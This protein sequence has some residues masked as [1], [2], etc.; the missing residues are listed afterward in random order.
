[1]VTTNRSTS[2]RVA[3]FIAL[4]LAFVSVEGCYYMQAV[5]GH[6]EVMRKRRPLDDVLTDADADE[7][8]KARLRLIREARQF[9]VD[10]LLL[11]DNDSY[12]TYAD[13]ERDYVV[14][15]VFAAPEFSLEPKQWCFPVAGCVAYKGYFD[16]DRARAFAQ[17]LEHKGYDVAVGGVAAYSTLGRFDDPVLNTMLHW[18][19]N[20]LVETLFHELAHQKLY[21]KG[22]SGFNESFASAVAEI[23]LERWL[24]SRGKAVDHR[25][26][27]EYQ[28]LQMAML[29][30]VSDYRSRL[31][32]LY[33][34]EL[35]DELRR[36][37][38]RALLDELSARAEGLVEDSGLDTT[39]WL[40][41]PL[42]NARLASIGLY[43]GEVP[44]FRSLLDA[45]QESLACFYDRAESLARMDSDARAAE[46]RR[47]AG[48]AN[49]DVQGVERGQ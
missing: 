25:R 1:V 20:V 41:A 22:D 28:A 23:G 39:N 13:L 48:D 36:T 16:E 21:I 18:S 12:R 3:I 40:A 37:Q 17:D 26:M 6:M 15:N 29:Q 45:C 35:T 19:D 44:S 2:W 32:K 30:L 4:A 27:D 47:L 9:S 24:A 31:E 34:A 11:P 7:R 38:K 10:E 46:L 14:W 49:A 5:G 8:L 33:A 42:N 43:E